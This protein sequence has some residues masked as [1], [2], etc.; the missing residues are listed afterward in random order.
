VQ[1]LEVLARDR[2][3]FYLNRQ[4]RAFQIFEDQMACGLKI[5]DAQRAATLQFYLQDD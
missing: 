5:P 2:A 1:K 3:G 4:I